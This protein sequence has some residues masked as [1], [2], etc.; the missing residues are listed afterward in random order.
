MNLKPKKICK[1]QLKIL[2]EGA[3]NRRCGLM[4]QTLG[5]AEDKD[6]MLRQLYAGAIHDVDQRMIL[7]AFLF[8]NVP[9]SLV[10]SGS[11]LP[12]LRIPIGSRTGGGG[13]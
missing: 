5:Y 3:R 12:V 8:H 2:R 7:L 9:C 13:R 10:P 4:T 6:R 1:R 11:S